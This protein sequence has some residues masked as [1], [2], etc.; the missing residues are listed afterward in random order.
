MFVDVLGAHELQILINGCHSS[1]W[2]RVNVTMSR[3][4]V[5]ENIFSIIKCA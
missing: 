2:M 4:E 5:F 3:V 1:P